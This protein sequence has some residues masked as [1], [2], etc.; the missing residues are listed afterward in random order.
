MGDVYGAQK[1]AGGRPARVILLLTVARGSALPISLTGAHNQPRHATIGARKK[2][3]EAG[4]R[5]AYHMVDF[6]S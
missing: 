2:T 6:H 3:K 1:L 4:R 5:V